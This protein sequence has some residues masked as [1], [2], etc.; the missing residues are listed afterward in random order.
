MRSATSIQ[1][2]GHSATN[3]A[4]QGGE[5][6]RLTVNFAVLGQGPAH[7][8]GVI[9]TSDFWITPSRDSPDFN[10]STAIARSGKPK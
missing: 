3:I 4:G 5:S 9:Y 8:A 7:V 10:G 6:T 2:L 1:F